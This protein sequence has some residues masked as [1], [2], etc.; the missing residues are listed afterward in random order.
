MAKKARKMVKAEKVCVEYVGPGRRT[1]RICGKVAKREVAKMI[2]DFKK[3]LKAPGVW[4]E[5]F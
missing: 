3:A 5:R 4:I 2:K 1:K